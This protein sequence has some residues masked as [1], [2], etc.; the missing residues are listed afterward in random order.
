M[1]LDQE[2]GFVPLGSN[3]PTP[4][5]KHHPTAVSGASVATGHTLYATLQWIASRCGIEQRGIEPV[6]PEQ[7]DDK[8][9]LKVG[10]M[11]RNTAFRCLY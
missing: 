10:T 7:R 1:A 11:V 8:G 9:T 6:P 5:E 4:R 2:S 3:P